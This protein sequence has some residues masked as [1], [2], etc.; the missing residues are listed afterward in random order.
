VLRRA[1]PMVVLGLGAGLVAG[2]L[3]ARGARAVLYGVAPLDPL[4]LTVAVL[5]MA[6]AAI[7]ATWVPARRIARIDPTAAIRSE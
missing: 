6:G 3:A 4:S 7:V 5:V 1:M 2:Y